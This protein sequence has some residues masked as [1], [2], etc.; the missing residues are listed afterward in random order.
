M[1]AAL[2]LFAESLRAVRTDTHAPHKAARQSPVT[3]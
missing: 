2:R 1:E 3:D